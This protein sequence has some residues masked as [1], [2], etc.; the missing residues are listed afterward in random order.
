M[1]ISRKQWILVA[2]LLALLAAG[3][4]Y[5][6]RMRAIPVDAVQ[7]RLVPLVRTVQFSARVEALSRVD[8]GS[9]V[10]GRVAEVLASDGAQV[11]QGALLVRLESEELRAVLAQALSSQQQ[12]TA[13]LAGLRSTGRSAASAGLAQARASVDA[14]QAEFVRVQQLVAQGFL[15]ASR[16]DDARRLRDVAVAQF[17]SARSQERAVGEAG[18][19]VVQAQAQAA[20]AAAAVDAARA[21]LAQTAILAP[22]DAQVL[23][24]AVEPGQ[25]VQPG[26]NLMTLA[27]AGPTQLV[28]QV[29]ERFLDQLAAGQSASAMADAYPGQRFAARVLAIAPT[30]D[31]Q[32]GSIEVKFALVE[33]LPAFLRQ[34]MT[35]SIEVETAR[36]ASALALPVAALAVTPEG[37]KAAVRLVVDGRIEERI[38]Q[39]GLRTLDA[40]EVTGGL[41]EGDLVALDATL[42]VGRKV[43]A[44]VVPVRL[45]AAP[46][47]GAGGGGAAALTNAMGR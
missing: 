22:S 9:T 17:D 11:R 43:R 34:D 14:T 2:A 28:A 16:L 1:A 5:A 20:L 26:K 10:T 21:R 32:R 37:A 12:A 33:A 3:I 30:V 41:V 45:V 7:M 39:L 6:V 27:L 40:V 35:L 25:I 29:D 46:K 23:S 8:I 47:A 44:Q 13:R 36:R 15:S 4:T 24:R 31:A 38:V 18:T 19:E 42:P